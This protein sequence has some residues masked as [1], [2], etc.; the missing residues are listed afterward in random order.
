MNDNDNDF[1]KKLKIALATAG[2]TQADLAAA[3]GVAPSTLNAWLR[4]RHP[5]PG[6]EARLVADIEVALGLATGALGGGR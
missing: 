5:A 6:G 4:G 3:L 1:E 2:R